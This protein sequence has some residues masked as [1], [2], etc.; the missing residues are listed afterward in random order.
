M[1]EAL[2]RDGAPDS[3]GDAETWHRALLGLAGRLPDDLVCEARAWLA[4]DLRLD[5]A[6]AIAFTATGGQVDLDDAE[7]RLIRDELAGS[8]LDGDLVLALDQLTRDPAPAP[9]VPGPHSTISQPSGYQRPGEQPPGSFPDAASAPVVPPVGVAW[10]FRSGDP[11]DDGPGAAM[12]RDLT[13]DPGAV[14]L[15]VID[16]AIVDAVRDEPTAVGLWRSWRVPAGGLSWP[17]P[18]RVYIVTVASMP[19]VEPPSLP[20]PPSEPAASPLAR[21][22][23]AQVAARL[24]AVLAATGELD[25]QVE[26]CPTGVEPPSYQGCARLCGALLW[27]RRP[28]AEVTIARVFDEVD[29]VTGPGFAADR[30]RLSDP[31]TRADL[32]R[33]LDLG[34]PVLG[35]SA[36]MTDVLDPDRGEVVPMTF[37]T[38]G[39]WVWTDTTSYY[40]DQHGIVPDPDL[41]RHLLADPAAADADE[42]ALHRVLA[43]LLG[44]PTREPVWVVPQMDEPTSAPVMP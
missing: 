36:R 2:E 41:V 29:P 44:R 11:A 8:G 19:P 26:V 30:P 35:T 21:S 10:E 1:T 17:R 13:G 37:R 43:N 9:G 14:P 24:G 28:A 5:V 40:L 4:A 12:P 16:Q 6:Q 27:A 31:D 20:S 18:R 15:S 25:P 23:P 34:I 3:A 32:L 39:V 42:V 22:R 7:L 38:D 33:R